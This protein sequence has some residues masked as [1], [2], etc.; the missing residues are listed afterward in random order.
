MVEG[1]LFYM[2]KKCRKK[3]R[4]NKKLNITEGSRIEQ[5]MKVSVDTSDELWQQCSHCNEW[6]PLKD[7][8]NITD[9]LGDTMVCNNCNEYFLSVE[10]YSGG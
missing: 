4:K 8:I 1:M 6:V 3:H 10:C 7:L 5:K 9:N 2:C